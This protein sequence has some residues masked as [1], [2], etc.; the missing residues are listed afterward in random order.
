MLNEEGLRALSNQGNTV[1]ELAREVLAS[2]WTQISETNLPT[3]EDEVMDS[4]KIGNRE[5]GLGN[6]DEPW[7]M[8]F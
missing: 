1:G 7:R 4:E 2:R 8:R 5:Q 6:E 3:D